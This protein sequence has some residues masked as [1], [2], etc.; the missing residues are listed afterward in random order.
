MQNV[1]WE[2]QWRMQNMLWES[3]WKSQI[4]CNFDR[5]FVGAIPTA[6]Y[7]WAIMR[8]CQVSIQ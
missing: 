3:Q 6:Y 4:G 1:N 8:D 2:S 7:L 5:I